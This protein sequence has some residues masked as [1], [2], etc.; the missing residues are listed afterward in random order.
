MITFICIGNFQ[1]DTGTKGDAGRKGEMGY[2]GL[3]GDKGDSY[4]ATHYF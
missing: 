3:K 2:Q 1:K 4:V